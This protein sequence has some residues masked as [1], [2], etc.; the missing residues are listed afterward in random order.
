MVQKKV[1]HN[2]GESG[3]INVSGRELNQLGLTTDS[4]VNLDIAESKD[5]AHAVID[6][7]D[8]ER[9]LIVTPAE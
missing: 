2:S 8:T 4:L 6:S 3:R 1:G 7:K 9:F 5:I